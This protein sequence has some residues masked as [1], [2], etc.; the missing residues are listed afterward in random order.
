MTQARTALLILGVLL[1]IAGVLS[2]ECSDQ[3]I[4]DSFQVSFVKGRNGE[5]RSLD[6][7]EV[8]FDYGKVKTCVNNEEP[9]LFVP[10]DSWVEVAGGRKRRN[11]WSWNVRGVKPCRDTEFLLQ[12]GD[13]Q[14]VNTLEAQSDQVLVDHYY[15]LGATEAVTY[16]PRDQVVEWSE[17]I[18]ATGY[19]IEMVD[20]D[21]KIVE[22]DV[23]ENRLSSEIADL[24]PCQYMEMF[25]TPYV[26]DSDNRDRRDET[27]FDF[28]KIPNISQGFLVFSDVTSNSVDMKVQ[29]DS[30]RCVESLSVEIAE[31]DSDDTLDTKV[32]NQNSNDE[33]ISFED[34]IQETDYVIKIAVPELEAAEVSSFM[35]MSIVNLKC[36]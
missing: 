12:I 35:L 29:L 11:T 23:T 30:L 18:C 14:V 3:V 21:Q 36:R 8:T 15:S 27:K 33:T 20:I 7:V 2:E 4:K 24:A 13:K 6:T 31:R 17:V 19:H 16:I 22:H 34:L 1:G 32:L 26:M 25:I 5:I 9:K 28:E 10:N